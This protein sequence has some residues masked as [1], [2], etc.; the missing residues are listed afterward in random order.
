MFFLLTAAERQDKERV[1]LKTTINQVYLLLSVTTMR[2]DIDFLYLSR[3]SECSLCVKHEKVFPSLTKKRS[4][5]YLFSCLLREIF[6]G[7]RRKVNIVQSIHFSSA[8]WHCRKYWF[9]SQIVDIC[10]HYHHHTFYG[11]KKR[12]KTCLLICMLN[13]FLKGI[14]MN[15]RDINVMQLKLLQPHLKFIRVFNLRN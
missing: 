1:S 3:C 5:K 8:I 15:E 9:G 10:K 7:M 6:L 4:F 11:Y 12:F 2:R 14:C 13:V